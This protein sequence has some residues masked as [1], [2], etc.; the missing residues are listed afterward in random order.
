MPAVFEAFGKG[1]QAV[2]LLRC[3]EAPFKADEIAVAVVVRE[4]TGF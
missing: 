4:G 1:R 2:K 3:Q